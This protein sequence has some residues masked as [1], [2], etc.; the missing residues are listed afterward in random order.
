MIGLKYLKF[1]QINVL[2]LLHNIAALSFVFLRYNHSRLPLNCTNE[3]S[4]HL[5]GSCVFCTISK[6]IVVKDRCLFLVAK[7]MILDGEP[8]GLR[9]DV[10]KNFFF[11]LRFGSSVSVNL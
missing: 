5:G 1:Q 10:Q 2:L 7:V 8:L 9:R 6:K 3:Y 11:E 4:S